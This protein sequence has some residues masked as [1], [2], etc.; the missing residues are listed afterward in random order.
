[1]V[2]LSI[3]LIAFVSSQV[4]LVWRSPTLRCT[5]FSRP[6]SLPSSA[7]LRFTRSLI[8]GFALEYTC[9][10]F[11]LQRGPLNTNMVPRLRGRF[12]HSPW[13]LLPCRHS[14]SLRSCL[15]SA[16]LS[17]APSLPNRPAD[18]TMPSFRYILYLHSAISGAGLPLEVL[19]FT[20]SHKLAL[21]LRTHTTPLCPIFDSASLRLG[22]RPSLATA[23]MVASHQ[24][25]Q[26]S[27]CGHSPIVACLRFKDIYYIF[28]L[29]FTPWLLPHSSAYRSRIFGYIHIL[30]SS[31]CLDGLLPACLY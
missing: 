6:P 23:R 17:L 26:L 9:S 10:A 27:S 5:P 15:P 13:S 24:R 12:A 11:D 8:S 14:H 4:S 31:T 21:V 28:S 1:M 20:V 3:P 7:S 29:G 19:T 25:L 30:D 2:V 22:L 18:P 16:A